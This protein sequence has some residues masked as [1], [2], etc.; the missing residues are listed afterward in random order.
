[1]EPVFNIE[2]DMVLD[3][4][5]MPGDISSAVHGFNKSEKIEVTFTGEQGPILFEQEDYK[6]ILIPPVAVEE[7]EES[8][9][10]SEG[11]QDIEG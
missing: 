2:K 5:V 4:P 6:A 7:K 8:E 3:I 10:I 11:Q 9:G 1:M